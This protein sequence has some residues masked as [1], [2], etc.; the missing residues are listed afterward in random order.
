MARILIQFHALPEEL[1]PLAARW[2][3]DHRLR[4]VGLKFFPFEVV[5][6]E[7]GD[8]HRVFA[9]ESLV[10][11][12][13]F[14]LQTPRLRARSKL[15]FAD[16]NPNALYLSI[17]RS[18]PS[19]LAESCLSGRSTDTKA[20]MVWRR[21]ARDLRTATEAGVLAINTATGRSCKI[22]THRFTIGAKALDAAGV[23]IL[24]LNKGVVLRLGGLTS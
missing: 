11:E 5:S 3:R 10:R 14:S 16:R 15:E 17:G 6:I 9:D 12:V 20:I 13:A 19:G 4:V 8:L 1:S 22:R 18:S 24:P 21:I 7:P 2:V 23:P